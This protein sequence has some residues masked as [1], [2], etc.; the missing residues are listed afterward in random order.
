MYFMN[1][2]WNC[3]TIIY[4]CDLLSSDMNLNLAHLFVS[5]VVISS[6]NDN[7]I[8]YFEQSG[9]IF[10]PLLDQIFPVKYP[11]ILFRFANGPDVHLWPQEHMLDLTD[12]F[13]CFL[14]VT[15]HERQ[16]IKY[17]KINS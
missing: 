13:I 1:L 7:F 8:E 15:V 16:Y 9:N 14:D 6:I 4:Y 2:N 17:N 12:L 11:H 5:L 10:N 3:L